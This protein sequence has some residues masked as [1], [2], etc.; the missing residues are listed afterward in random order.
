MINE[1]SRAVKGD[2]S[3]QDREHRR[4]DWKGQFFVMDSGESI[5]ERPDDNRDFDQIAGCTCPADIA[6]YHHLVCS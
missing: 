1:P 6:Q 4:V 2:T 3:I 5:C